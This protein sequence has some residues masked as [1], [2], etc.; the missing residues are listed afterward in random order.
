VERTLPM[1]DQRRVIVAVGVAVAQELLG[2]TLRFLEVE[3]VE[4]VLL[5]PSLEP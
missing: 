1:L 3:T 2:K 5:L 4:Q